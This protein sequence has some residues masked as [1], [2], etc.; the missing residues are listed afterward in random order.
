MIWNQMFVFIKIN[1]F[2]F[3]LAIL[4]KPLEYPDVYEKR[5]SLFKIL[6]IEKLK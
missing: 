1:F 2:I 4:I 5:G 6:W 3:S